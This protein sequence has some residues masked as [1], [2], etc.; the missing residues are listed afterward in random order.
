MGRQSQNM[1]AS[2]SALGLQRIRCQLLSYL[3]EPKSRLREPL[4]ARAEGPAAHQGTQLRRVGCL[5]VGDI[6]LLRIRVRSVWGR[7]SSH[8]QQRQNEIDRRHH[9][10]YR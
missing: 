10:T 7:S 1:T 9:R 4:T 5:L 8:V 2:E 3:A 6:Y